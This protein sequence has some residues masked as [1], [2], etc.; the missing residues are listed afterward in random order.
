MIDQNEKLWLIEVNTNP[1]IE[2][3]S[4][5]LENLLPRMIDDAFKKTIDLVF[6]PSKCP[7]YNVP[8]YDDLVNMFSPLSHK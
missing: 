3:S 5:L 2:T 1:C 6:K 8:G 4:K 7:V